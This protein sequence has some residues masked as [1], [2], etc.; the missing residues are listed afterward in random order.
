MA[1]KRIVPNIAAEVLGKA[2]AFCGDVLGLR[3]VMDLGWILTFATDSETVPPINFATEG[4][5]GAPI[6][7]LSV[8]VDN[9][10]EVYRR[11]RTNTESNT[12]RCLSH[13]AFGD[14]T[15]AIIS[16]AWSTSWPTSEPNSGIQGGIA[17]G[18][19]TGALYRH[20][21]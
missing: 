19:S 11:T 16:A 8:E 6:P 3:V 9:L 1:V 15:S 20:R 2:K 14:S 10:D 17:N 13:G 5:S 12:D 7:D 4:G 18:Y 21:R